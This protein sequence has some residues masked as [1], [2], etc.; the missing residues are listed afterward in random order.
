[1]RVT[2]SKAAAIEATAPK[3][4]YG[5]PLQ[6][7]AADATLHARVTAG[8]KRCTP[9]NRPP[10]T[11]QEALQRNDWTH[12]PPVELLSRRLMDMEPSVRDFA[13]KTLAAINMLDIQA[14]NVRKAAIRLGIIDA[15]APKGPKSGKTKGRGKAK[16]G[17]SVMANGIAA[18]DGKGRS[19]AVQKADTDGAGSDKVSITRGRK[20]AR[21]LKEDGSEQSGPDVK[22]ARFTDSDTVSSSEGDSSAST[23][24]QT[25]ADPACGTSQSGHG[26][27]SGG[28]PENGSG[29][30]DGPSRRCSPSDTE[31]VLKWL[32]RVDGAVRQT[33]A[34]KRCIPVGTYYAD[35]S[36]LVCLGR[37]SLTVA[38]GCMHRCLRVELEP[39]EDEDPSW[40]RAIERLVKLAG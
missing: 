12:P 2:R 15:P 19:E 13:E 20:R 34:L 18:A 35:V 36:Q 14:K 26:S 27:D 33:R 24:Q 23:S 30:Q 37:D 3:I 31:T 5:S 22:R 40:Q 4:E 29:C 8:A 25:M 28:G 32:K 6:D 1:M 11:V 16:S 10:A 17:G 38:W 39:A 7:A 9:A 21:S